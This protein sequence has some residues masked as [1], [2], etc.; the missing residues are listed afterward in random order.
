M[1]YILALFQ[2]VSDLFAA[3]FLPMSAKYAYVPYR[4]EAERIR[5][6]QQASRSGLPR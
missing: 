4:T 5:R 2:K 6:A 1:N 3:P